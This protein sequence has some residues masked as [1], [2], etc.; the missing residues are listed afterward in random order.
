MAEFYHLN[1][2][3]GMPVFQRGAV[4]SAMVDGRRASRDIIDARRKADMTRFGPAR[5]F[6]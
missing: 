5:F 4:A 6:C 2:L 1:D 3:M